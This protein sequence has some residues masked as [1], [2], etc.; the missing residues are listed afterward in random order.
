ME[1]DAM[2]VKKPR[3]TEGTEFT[4]LR[5]PTDLKR[6]AKA[7]AAVKGISFA[8]FVSDALREKLRREARG[9]AA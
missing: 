8:Q 3:A 7:A 2:G 9:K 4:S 6:Q 1:G 5:L